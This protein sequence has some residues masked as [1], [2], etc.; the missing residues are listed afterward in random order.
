M[1]RKRDKFRPCGVRLIRCVKTYESFR[2][3]GPDA[4]SAPSSLER[5]TSHAQSSVCPVRPHEVFG[6]P[7]ALEP[8]MLY[9]AIADMKVAP[10]KVCALYAAYSLR[11]HSQSAP[12]TWLPRGTD[13]YT[14]SCR[15]S[16]KQLK[17]YEMHA[18]ASTPTHLPQAAINMRYRANAD[19]L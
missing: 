11:S 16:I 15:V 3:G 5:R 4:L 1:L 10:G 8:P 9:L 2:T 18:A 13:K 6:N 19:I 17:L 14:L 12:L 7:R